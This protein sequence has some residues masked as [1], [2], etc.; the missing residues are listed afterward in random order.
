MNLDIII[1]ALSAFAGGVFTALAGF[2]DAKA[3]NPVEAWNWY[4]FGKSI[5]AAGI[6]GFVFA[7]GYQFRDVFSVYDVFIAILGGA[8]IEAGSNRVIGALTPKS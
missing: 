4:K 8:G 5:I 6:A 1:I 3:S 2:L 7:V